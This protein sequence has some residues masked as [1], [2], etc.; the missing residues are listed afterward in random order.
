MLYLKKMVYL[1]HFWGNDDWVHIYTVMT[2]T[3]SYTVNTTILAKPT[4]EIPFQGLYTYTVHYLSG[5]WLTSQIL[6]I[7]DKK[8]FK[9]NKNKMA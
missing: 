6:T 8:K 3:S 1:A 4:Q 7:R 9:K 5:K 2:K